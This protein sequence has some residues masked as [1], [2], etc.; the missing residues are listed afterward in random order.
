M[1]RSLHI[2]NIAVIKKADVDFSEGFT[3]LTG[4][5][6]AGKSIILDSIGLLLGAKAD[7]ELLRHG[8]TSAS[9]GALFSDLSGIC[10]GKFAELGIDAD[11]DHTV[12]IQRNLSADG[13]SQIKINGR[14]VNLSLLKQIA[15]MLMNIHGQND[16]GILLDKDSHIEVIDVYAKHAS[17]ID[18]YRVEYSKYE[19]IRKEI[20]DISKR[21]LEGERLRAVLEYQ[22]KDIDDVSPRVGEED[23]LIDKKV[24]I[25][26]SE[27]I[28]KNSEFAYRALKGSEKGSVAFLLDRSASALAQLDGIIPEYSSYAERIHDML[29]QIEDIAEDIAAVIGDVDEDPTDTLNEIESRL[30]KLSKLKRKYGLTLDAVLE[31]RST[32]A[33]ELDTLENTEHILSKLKKQEDDAYSAALSL[34]DQLNMSRLRASEDI[35]KKICDTLKFL[36][37]PNVVFY[38]NFST[39]YSAGSKIL[40]KNGYDNV[41]FYISTNKGADAQPLSKVASGGELARIMLA[42]KSIIADKDGVPT[43]IFDEVDS[44]VSGKTARKIGMKLKELSSCIQVMC[45][46]HSAQIASLSDKHLLISKRDVNNTTET[47][48]TNLDREGRIC[49]LSRILG[50]INV[51]D[52]QRAAAI[53]MLN[54]GEI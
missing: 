49:E 19:K 24:K 5:T 3:A 27:K 6:G 7:K 53:D 28:V 14:T 33:A 45:V 16:T 54:E 50:G 46:T 1:L 31:F 10:L 44:G 21:A 29:S 9:V 52:A 43:V 25:K 13:R 17:L 41:E 36:D 11:D 26:N 39:E 30:D 51:T 4:E 2:E 35:K 34:A 32:A 42:I 38:P 15:P 18:K 22:I 23:E 40:N 37:M 20:N 47:S 8:E 48:V 12:Y